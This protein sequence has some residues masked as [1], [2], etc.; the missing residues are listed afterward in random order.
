MTDK[1]IEF[2]FSPDLLE[3]LQN[4]AL[5]KLISSFMPDDDNMKDQAMR[6]IRCCNRHGVKTETLL[7]IAK[8][9]VE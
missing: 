3:H 1:D 6:L 4:A 8:D 2:M 9:L 5:N 7:E